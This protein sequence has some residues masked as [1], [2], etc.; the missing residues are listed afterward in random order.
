M[1]KSDFMFELKMSQKSHLTTK[2]TKY[3][4]RTQVYVRDCESFE[5]LCVLPWGP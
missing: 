5:I 4:R 2:V 1:N 3:A